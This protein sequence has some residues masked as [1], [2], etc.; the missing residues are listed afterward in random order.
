MTIINTKIKDM[1]LYEELVSRLEH[2]DRAFIVRRHIKLHYASSMP[3]ESTKVYIEVIRKYL[4]F[5][6]TF[7]E[8]LLWFITIELHSRFLYRK[9]EKGLT[10]LINT[11]A[12]NKEIYIIK[13][14]E[15]SEKHKETIRVI[16]KQRDKFFGHADKLPWTEFEKT[17]DKEIDLL[18]SD[19]KALLK[20]IGVSMG[21]SRTVTSTQKLAIE[22]TNNLFNDLVVSIDRNIKV[23]DLQ[24]IYDIGVEEFLKS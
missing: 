21:K 6:R 14:N 2:I 23:N 17:F 16:G 7:E 12:K 18:L 24:A 10:K 8:S 20:D 9:T 4:E 22:H 1:D 19:L 13:F 15:L 11:L 3:S 5:F